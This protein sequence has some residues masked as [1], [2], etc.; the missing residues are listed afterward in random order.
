MKK[1]QGER[2]VLAFETDNALSISDHPKFM[3][4]GNFPK[5]L[6][7]LL[8]RKKP[9]PDSSLGNVES[10]CLGGFHTNPGFLKAQKASSRDS[11]YETFL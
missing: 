7:K 8:M 3:E 5:H 1:Q 4:L 11:F 10:Q 9:V 2:S 6:G